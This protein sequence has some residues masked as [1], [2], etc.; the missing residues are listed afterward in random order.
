MAKKKITTR[1]VLDLQDDEFLE[2]GGLACGF[3]AA[4]GNPKTLNS[5]FG[6]LAQKIKSVTEKKATQ[7]QLE[8]LEKVAF[9]IQEAARVNADSV[10]TVKDGFID[11]MDTADGVLED[12]NR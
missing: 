10:D 4:A 6:R 11:L 2:L 12:L 1:I 9:A 5:P 3:F 7:G 8:Y